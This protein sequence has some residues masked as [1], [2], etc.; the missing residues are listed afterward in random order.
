VNIAVDAKGLQFPEKEGRRVEELTLLTVLEDELG[1]FVAGKESV[2]GLA[3]TAAT[4]AE[5]RQKGIEAATSF[6]VPRPGTYRVREV[7]REAA[8]N[9][10]WASGASIEVR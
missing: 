10:V 9:H 6:A 3:L 2:I 4:L 1:N 5:K 8:Q 7:I